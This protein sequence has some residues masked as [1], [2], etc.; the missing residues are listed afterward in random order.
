VYSLVGLQRTSSFFISQDKVRA[1]VNVGVLPTIGIPH[2]QEYLSRPS[3][4]RGF[5]PTACHY[6]ILLSLFGFHASTYK[7]SRAEL[8]PKSDVGISYLIAEFR[9]SVG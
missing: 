5:C 3:D 4:E 1:N 2:I 8:Q 7:G 9:V 6:P